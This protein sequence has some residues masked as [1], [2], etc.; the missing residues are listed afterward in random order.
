M[1]KLVTATLLAAIV[2]GLL[3]P[4][5]A[6]GPI[7]FG[8]TWGTSDFERST[9]VVVDASGNVFLAGSSYNRFS[10]NQSVFVLKFDPLGNLLW[11]RVLSLQVNDTGNL[12]LA[13]NGDVYFLGQI[14][15]QNG[16]AAVFVARISSAGSVVWA[17][18][19]PEVFYPTRI[20]TDPVTGGFFITSFG[21]STGSTVVSA[22][23][24]DGSLRW[25]RASG[26][27]FI[28][29]AGLAV[30]STGGPVLNY[31]R[32]GG[33]LGLASFDAQGNL[34]AQRFFNPYPSYATP[35]DVV[36]D[37]SGDVFALAQSNSDASFYLSRF[38]GTLNPMWTEKVHGIGYS[39]YPTRLVLMP[40]GTIIVL[41][42][43][44]LST[45]STMS[46]NLYDIGANGAVLSGSAYVNP[47]LPSGQS[48]GLY[49]YDGALLGS[50]G[51]VIA[52]TTLGVP[53]MDSQAV[54]ADVTVLSPSWAED[55]VTWTGAN[56]VPTDLP[57]PV[58]DP[59]VP[60]DDFSLASGYQAWYGVAN[61]PTSKLSVTV[62]SSPLPQDPATVTFSATVTGGRKPYSFTWSFG[63]GASGTESA[64][65]HTYSGTGKYLVQ[66]AVKDSAGI[67][68]YGHT[69]VMVPG[70]PTILAIYMYPSPVGYAGSWAYFYADVIDADGGSI[71]QYE[72]SYGDG[73]IDY[74]YYPSTSHIYYST[75]SYTLTL[76]VTDNDQGLSS[77]MSLAVEIVTAPDV[78]PY[79]SFYWTPYNPTVNATVTFYAYNSYDPDG[80][81]TMYSWFFGDGSIFNSSSPY[82]WHNYAQ[83][84]AY[85]VTLVV[86]DNGGMTGTMNQTLVVM[87]DQPPVA[88]FSYYPPIPLA[89]QT[90]FF[91]GGNSYDR[92]GYIVSWNWSFGDGSFGD[93]RDGNFSG[94][95]PYVSHVYELFG[96]YGVRLTVTDN[97]GLSA[98]T[99]QT[100][101]V[102]APP[103]AVITPARGI[104]KVGTLLAFS[105]N[106]SFDPDG[107]IMYYNWSFGD[108]SYAR[109][110]WATH[111]YAN[112]GQYTVGLI[113]L[114]AYGAM[115][116]ATLSYPVTIPVP[117]VAVIAWTPSRAIAGST[118][119]AFDGSNSL[120]PDGAIATY[121]WEF[122]DGTVGHGKTATHSY[123]YTGTY[124]VELVVLDEDGLSD[125]DVQTLSVV[126][127]S[128][129]VVTAT[130]QSLPLAGA[131]VTL[132]QRGA[133]VLAL[134]T[135]ADGTF[136]LG[137]LAPGTYAIAIA[138]AGYRTYEGT[139]AWDGLNG[140]L[141]TFRLEPAALE[142]TGFVPMQI[143]ILGV[144]AVAVVVGGF[145][146]ARALRRRRRAG[147]LENRR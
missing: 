126:A 118:V 136:S 74:T 98:S 39:D 19:V 27:T 144:L 50:G 17:K 72:W 12:A 89:N 146:A 10:G 102:D 30:G 64:P 40:A 78:P 91:N 125:R 42:P 18:S 123:A 108:A 44:Y 29:P 31:R 8:H 121:I 131:Q 92:D 85:P 79:A 51:I 75:G 11:N 5:A 116:V 132:S 59:V 99:N 128:K 52:G 139:L 43:A 49:P 45:N 7:Q 25:A 36:A 26:G 65:T 69:V 119:V 20:A 16:S 38:N 133:V 54:T 100:I 95:G 113:V 97:G 120:D 106:A 109:G 76:T 88:T 3:L 82:A 63:D 22:Y 137:D 32:E 114:D 37:P 130:G 87:P 56:L 13:P 83:P 129:G 93:G 62:T 21:S 90:V 33:S 73:F 101:Y 67:V 2:T 57:V 15:G 6:A 80:Y 68:G 60:V 105:A 140:D 134:L 147:P 71:V 34:L 112:P 103:V 111:V 122:G 46:T 81:I 9:S 77:S 96:S 86:T 84:G 127:Q 70:P 61:V 115:S 28:D 47:V 4:L 135:A 41:G 138:K 124:T 14:Y 58:S 117:P 104:G 55:V 94:S 107:G 110:P 35:Q 48:T 141:G 66:V 1:R 143:G 23:T 24:S 142:P 53:P 145:V